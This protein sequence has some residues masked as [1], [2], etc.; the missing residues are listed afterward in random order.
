MA[1]WTEGSS[2]VGEGRG[3]RWRICRGEIE[4][5]SEIHAINLTR[6]SRQEP[7]DLLNSLPASVH[8][9]I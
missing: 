3:V 1:R 7:P 8:A 5:A 9:Q 2:Q 4:A 6:Q